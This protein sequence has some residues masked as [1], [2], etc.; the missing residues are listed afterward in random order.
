MEGHQAACIHRGGMPV[1]GRRH[2]QDRGRDACLPSGLR[3][4]VGVRSWAISHVTSSLLGAT[5][6]ILVFTVA[7][8]LAAGPVLGNA[9]QVLGE[10]ISGGL[11]QLAGIAVTGS[12]ALALVAL[13][14]RWASPIAWVAYVIFVLLGPLFGPSLGLP[15]WAQELSPF[16]HI[17]KAPAMAISYLPIVAMA[18]AAMAL[19]AVG[20]GSLPRPQPLAPRLSGERFNQPRPHIALDQVRPDPWYAMPSA[21]RPGNYEIPP[22]RDGFLVRPQRA[23][24]QQPSEGRLTVDRRSNSCRRPSGR[25]PVLRWRDPDRLQA[26][27]RLRNPGGPRAQVE[28]QLCT[29]KAR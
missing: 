27:P 8:G 5:L 29:D 22:P 3:S 20:Y 7:M 10:L 14:P 19:T 18:G 28:H 15:A 1:N 6:L 16:T 9:T 4:R 17:P 11:V 2:G 24:R 23:G 26:S 21:G 25:P 12:A 13:A